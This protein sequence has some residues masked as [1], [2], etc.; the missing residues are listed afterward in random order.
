MK[1]RGGLAMNKGWGWPVLVVIVA[2]GAYGAGW[3]SGKSGSFVRGL[4]EV[5]SAKKEIERNL[6][7]ALQTLGKDQDELVRLAQ[8]KLGLERQIRALERKTKAP[9]PKIDAQPPRKTCVKW[10]RRY[11]EGCG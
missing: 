10:G 6:D 3:A 2:L 11:Q 7:Q 5:A 9:A 1:Q 8:E 4:I